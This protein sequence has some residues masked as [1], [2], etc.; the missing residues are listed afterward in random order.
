MHFV[1]IAQKILYVGKVNVDTPFFF[2]FFF[3][4]LNASEDAQAERSKALNWY[5]DQEEEEEEEEEGGGGGRRRHLNSCPDNKPTKILPYFPGC[6]LSKKKKKSRI[7]PQPC[8][9]NI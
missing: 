1:G 2:F 8:Q 6:A 7:N 3:P 9:T 5:A 4:S